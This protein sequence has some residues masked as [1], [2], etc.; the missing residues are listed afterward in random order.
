[1][2]FKETLSINIL[3]SQ[4]QSLGEVVD[5]IDGREEVF[6][7]RA[8]SEDTRSKFELERSFSVSVNTPGGSPFTTGGKSRSES[9]KSRQSFSSRHSSLDSHLDTDRASAA[10]PHLFVQVVTWAKHNIF[11]SRSFCNHTKLP[12]IENC[13]KELSVTILF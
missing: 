11:W 12:K 4:V 13:F 2:L 5:K 8:A 9:C 1:M 6:L 3:F 7:S 10:A